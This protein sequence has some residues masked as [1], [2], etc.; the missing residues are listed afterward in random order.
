MIQVR[1]VLSSWLLRLFTWQPVP[2]VPPVPRVPGPPQVQGLARGR[3]Q[4]P[5]QAQPWGPGPAL[6]PFCILQLQKIM[7]RRK[8]VKK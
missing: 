3:V 8:T 7:P 5:G 4:V 2:P 6:Q 1:P